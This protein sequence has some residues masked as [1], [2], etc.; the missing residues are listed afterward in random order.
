MISFSNGSSRINVYYSKMTVA[1]VV[2]HPKLGRQTLYRKGIIFQDL[3]KI[4]KNPRVHLGTG[5]RR[6]THAGS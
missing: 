2:D 4:F 5:Y 6:R 3:E 1:T